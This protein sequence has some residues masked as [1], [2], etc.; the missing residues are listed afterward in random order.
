[1]LFRLAELYGKGLHEQ[2]NG[3]TAAHLSFAHQS[4]AACYIS[5]GPEMEGWYEM[6]MSEIMEKTG[7]Q[8]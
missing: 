5:T 4:K 2:M 6:P 8:I 1:M 3:F 7:Y